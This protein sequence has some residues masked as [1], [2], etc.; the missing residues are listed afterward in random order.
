MGV[1]Y[2]AERANSIRIRIRVEM[3]IFSWRFSKVFGFKT[4]MCYLFPSSNV[5]ENVR[6]TRSI[7]FAIIFSIV[8]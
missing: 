3:E 6:D 1:G 4:I 5:R 2:A 8:E 7:V